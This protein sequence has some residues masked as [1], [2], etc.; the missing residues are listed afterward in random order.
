MLNII[1]KINNKKICINYSS[2]EFILLL[3]EPVKDL[4]NNYELRPC[5]KKTHKPKFDYPSYSLDAKLIGVN[6]DRVSFIVKDSD[7]IILKEKINN[8]GQ[9]TSEKINENNNNR[10]CI[11]F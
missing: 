11:L 4:R 1:K 7:N 9:K 10:N 8:F 2:N 3:K 6:K 5:K